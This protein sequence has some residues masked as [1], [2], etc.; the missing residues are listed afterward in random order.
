MHTKG[1][2]RPPK[3]A[4]MLDCSVRQLYN[5]ER[6]DPD[7]PRKLVFSP[8]FVGYRI[9]SLEAYLAKKE[10]DLIGKSA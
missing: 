9:E 6:D 5:L 1:I 4:V 10:A 8:R 2:A 7:F 3:A